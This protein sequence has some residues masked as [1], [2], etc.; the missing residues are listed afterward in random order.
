MVLL[1]G[2][3]TGPE[4]PPYSAHSS[5]LPPL[6]GPMGS[7]I[8]QVDVALIER[9]F[10]DPY[11]NRELWSLLDD[12]IAGLEKKTILDDNG[13]R[14]GQVVGPTPGDFLALLTDKKSN[15]TPRQYSRRAGDSVAIDLG[16]VMETCR[17][18]I[19]GTKKA[20]PHA[21]CK[22]IVIPTLASDGR[23][24]LQFTPQINHG[25]VRMVPRPNAECSQWELKEV[26]PTE[27]YHHLSWEVTL[28]PGELLVIGGSY[29]RQQ[30]LGWQCFARRDEPVPVQRLLVVRTRCLAA[31]PAELLA[32]LDDD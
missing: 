30:S 2:C 14:V 5:G 1:A 31:G 23:V 25:E 6:L 19:E 29:D 20:L 32:P 16:P 10:A 22:L 3:I 11:I 27:P 24:K 15:A 9:P 26:Q 18:E 13:F 8:V 21:Q 4:L 28:A 17:F 12:Q 7:D